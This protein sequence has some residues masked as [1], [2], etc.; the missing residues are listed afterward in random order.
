[1]N[2]IKIVKDSL[3]FLSS[4]PLSHLI[5]R[6][7]LAD[8]DEYD[9]HDSGLVSNAQTPWAVLALFSSGSGLLA[10]T[11][12]PSPDPLVVNKVTAMTGGHDD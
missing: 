9:A 3:V 11:S 6:Q 10:Q 5:S 1:M 8:Q 2:T 4:T 7:G 12:G